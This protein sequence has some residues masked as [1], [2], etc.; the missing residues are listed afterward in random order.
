MLVPGAEHDDGPITAPSLAIPTLENGCR[1]GTRCTATWCSPGTA[2]RWCPLELLRELLGK[3]RRVLVL[4][5]CRNLE[6][7]PVAVDTL[8]KLSIVA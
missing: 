3:A 5:Q 8:E 1:S 7:G 2:V 6:G 4:G